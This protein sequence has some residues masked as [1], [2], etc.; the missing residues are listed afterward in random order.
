[1]LITLENN[2]I[3]WSCALGIHLI[4]YAHL[5]PIRVPPCRAGRDRILFR[6]INFRCDVCTYRTGSLQRFVLH[7]MLSPTNHTIG[8]PAGVNILTGRVQEEARTGNAFGDV[9]DSDESIEYDPDN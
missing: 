1:M 4:R 9:T 8:I 2:G 6:R 5:T 3:E 7:I